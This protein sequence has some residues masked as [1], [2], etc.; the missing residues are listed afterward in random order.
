MGPD[1]SDTGLMRLVI[2]DDSLIEVASDRQT[3][4]DWREVWMVETLQD[5]AYVY[6][7]PRSAIIIPQRSFNGD[8][9]F[10]DL[11]TEISKRIPKTGGQP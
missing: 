9:A 4:I 7:G 5:R 8:R 1:A 11:L 10:K 3:K 2:T 6:N